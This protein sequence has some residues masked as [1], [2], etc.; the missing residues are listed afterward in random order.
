MI[1]RVEAGRELAAGA[2]AQLG[3]SLPELVNQGVTTISMDTSKV[4]EF[5]SQTLQAIL[6]FD[7]LA[8]SRG[9]E[10][11]VDRPSVVLEQALIITGLADRLDVR[12]AAGASVSGTSAAGGRA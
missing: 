6:E 1:Q 11:L 7:A 8:R 10:V 5:D 9:L 3:K 12:N 2:L 4:V